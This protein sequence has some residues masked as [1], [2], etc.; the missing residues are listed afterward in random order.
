MHGFFIPDG[1]TAVKT[2]AAAPG[3]HPE[4]RVVYRPALA[5][6]RTE[7]H[8]LTA[9]GDVD[10]RTRFENDLIAR[11]VV[12][13]GGQPVTPDQAGRL[14]PALRVDL[15]NLVLGYQGADEE[16]GEKKGSPTGSA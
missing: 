12:E 11:Q 3:L 5:R 16:A 10:R 1:H 13:L 8:V 15:L 7:Y 6:V 4:A 2:L 9:G 14:V